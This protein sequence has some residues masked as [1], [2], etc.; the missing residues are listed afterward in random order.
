MTRGFLKSIA[1]YISD[2]TFRDDDI[3]LLSN[4]NGISI[5]VDESGND[6]LI[7]YDKIQYFQSKYH[8]FYAL[9]SEL[10]RCSIEEFASTKV[11][12]DM[13]YLQ[14][15]YNN[16]YGFYIDDCGEYCGLQTLDEFVRRCDR[17]RKYY[18]GVTFDYHF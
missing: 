10:S 11:E 6:Y 13:Q 9:L 1:D 16:Q 15:A 17:M 2:D 8:N 5:G 18:I 3:A 14:D 4:R 12:R 7:V